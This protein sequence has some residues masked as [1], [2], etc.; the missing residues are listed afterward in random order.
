MLEGYTPEKAAELA[1]V[2]ESASI[3]GIREMTKDDVPQVHAILSEYLK[4]FTL[5]PI[6]TEEGIAHWL[7]PRKGIV[8]TYVVVDAHNK[9]TDFVSYHIVPYNVLKAG[10]EC[11]VISRTNH[12]LA[13]CFIMRPLKLP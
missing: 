13:I 5:H 6:F 1:E 9:A 8:H 4:K 11:Q 3:P 12:S 7:L 10:I 2:P